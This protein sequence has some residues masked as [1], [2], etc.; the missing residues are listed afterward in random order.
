MIDRTYHEA[1][2]AARERKR[3]A[4]WLRTPI[5]GL[6]SLLNERELKVCRALLDATAS[7]VEANDLREDE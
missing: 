4:A 2:G 1:M 6:D 7:M 3:I 5:T